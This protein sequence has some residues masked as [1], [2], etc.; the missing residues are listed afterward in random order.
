MLHPC[1]GLRPCPALPQLNEPK[2]AEGIDEIRKA[3]EF[4]LDRLGQDLNA[5]PIWLE[6][7]HF[8]QVGGWQRAW[9]EKC[10]WVLLAE[11]L[12]WK[13][14]VVLAEGLLR[15]SRESVR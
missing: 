14:H 7:T 10:M 3:Y 8:L 6:Y 15:S 4:T 1:S 9:F 13:W 2:G 11:R 5:G 12:F